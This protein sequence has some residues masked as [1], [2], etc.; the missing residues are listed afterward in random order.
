MAQ[1]KGT[2][3][4]WALVLPALGM[5]GLLVASCARVTPAGGPSTGGI[6]SGKPYGATVTIGPQDAGKTVTLGAGD[7]LVFQASASGAS[8]SAVGW[9]LVSYP[10]DL[11]TLLSWASPSPFRFRALHPGTWMLELSLGPLCGSPGPA[12]GDSAQCP[13]G[14][15]GQAAEFPSRLLTFTLHVLARGQ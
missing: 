9:R 13:V 4:R 2:A 14:A 7:L 12:K 5:I 11:I 6:T 8:P 15:K 10:K 1:R 3:P